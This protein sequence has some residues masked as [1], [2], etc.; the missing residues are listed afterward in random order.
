MLEYI[1][2]GIFFNYKSIPNRLEC[3]LALNY[4][5]KI[6]FSELEKNEKIEFWGSHPYKNCT[7]L[8]YECG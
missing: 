1:F 2:L 7:R 3:E 5:N 4:Q 6:K 8:L